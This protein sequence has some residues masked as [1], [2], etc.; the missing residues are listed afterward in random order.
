MKKWLLNPFEMLAGWASLG[1]GLCILLI[2][3]L[4]ACYANVHLDGVIDLH[5]GYHVS[6]KEIFLESLINWLCL[7]VFLYV[8]GFI[9][10]KSSIRILD[11]F[12]TQA[13]ARFPYLIATIVS[14]S[15]NNNKV[16]AFVEYHFLNK[17][18]AVQPGV[19]D[20]LVFAFST[21]TILLM[22]VWMV[23]L[24]YKA[25]S[26]SCNVKNVKGIF[27]FIAALVSA[28]ILSKILIALI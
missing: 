6:L 26:V 12:G 22:L 5:F 25:Y 15:L 23:Y 10:S 19:I 2:T 17:G 4:V 28:E 27:S 1:I 13:M 11:V 7:A 9:L 16:I 3:A 8:S 20:I 24:M 18:E 14:L 21:L